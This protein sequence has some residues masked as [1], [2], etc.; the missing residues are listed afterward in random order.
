[1]DPRPAK[2][3]SWS[4]IVRARKIPRPELRSA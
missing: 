3:K 4:D 2:L 1:M